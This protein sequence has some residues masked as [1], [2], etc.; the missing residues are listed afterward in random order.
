MRSVALLLV[1][2]ATGWT[3][4]YP[5]WSPPRVQFP[6][7]EVFPPRARRYPEVPRRVPPRMSWREHKDIQTDAGIV[8]GYRHAS[9][10]HYAFFG[11]PYAEPPIGDLRFK[12]QAL[13]IYYSILTTLGVT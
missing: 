12:V 8:R 4:L 3:D 10:P 9:P 11:V 1:Y 13:E 2:L 6:M 7:T 5:D